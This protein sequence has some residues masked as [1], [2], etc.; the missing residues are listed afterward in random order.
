MPRFKGIFAYS[1]C[2]ATTP[3][4]G[5]AAMHRH[6]EEERC[7]TDVRAPKSAAATRTPARSKEQQPSDLEW[8]VMINMDVMRLNRYGSYG[9][10][11]SNPTV[12]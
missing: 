12:I 9:P 11:D 6:E 4:L 3:A 8:T 10:H 5:S 7:L 1:L 2:N